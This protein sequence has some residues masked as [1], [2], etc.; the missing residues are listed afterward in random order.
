MVISQIIL[1]AEELRLFSEPLLYEIYIQ[2]VRYDINISYNV[3]RH[4][5]SGRTTP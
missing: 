5:C 2:V 4:F 3:V 1:Y